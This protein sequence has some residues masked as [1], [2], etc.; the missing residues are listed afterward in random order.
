ML[1][2]I[3][4]EYEALKIKEAQ[5]K[6]FLAS[7]NENPDSDVSKLVPMALKEISKNK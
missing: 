5:S 7:V 3:T 4:E 6:D 2:K 1:K